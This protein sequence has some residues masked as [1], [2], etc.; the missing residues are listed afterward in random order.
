MI[1]GKLVIKRGLV[2]TIRDRMELEVKILEKN[3]SGRMKLLEDEAALM[4]RHIE[5]EK[6]E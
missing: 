4:R 6:S 3:F 1:K 2:Q 5:V